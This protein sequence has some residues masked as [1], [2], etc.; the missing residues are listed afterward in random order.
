MRLTPGP[1]SVIPTHL[2]WQI[3]DCRH[4]ALVHITSWSQTRPSSL[5]LWWEHSASTECA[6]AFLLKFESSP[7]VIYTS[8]YGRKLDVVQKSQCHLN[9]TQKAVH[10]KKTEAQITMKEFQRSSWGSVSTD[11]LEERKSWNCKAG[12]GNLKHH[13]VKIEPCHQ[14]SSQTCSGQF[15]GQISM[16]TPSPW[17]SATQAFRSFQHRLSSLETS[18]LGVVKGIWEEMQSLNQHHHHQTTATVSTLGE[19]EF[20][21]LPNLLIL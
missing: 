1:W 7:L 8:I 17:H 2:G 9:P 14:Q 6:V 20:W 21:Y 15:P 12:H 10:Q 5:A 3:W 16:C 13:W 4:A 19:F 18:V 11:V